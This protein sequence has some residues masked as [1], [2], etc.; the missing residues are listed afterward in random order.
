MTTGES[1]KKNR[2]RLISFSNYSICITLPKKA[3]E[4]LGWHKGT[5][6]DI[7]VN[8]GNRS[9]TLS[10]TSVA[11]TPPAPPIEAATPADP[12]IK[13]YHAMQEQSEE[14]NEA[15]RW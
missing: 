5:E 11:I 1:K 13:P 4:E 12:I 2:R 14:V 15:L 10:R 3:L 6:V 9:M 7:N 8:L